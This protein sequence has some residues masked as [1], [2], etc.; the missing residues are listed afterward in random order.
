MKQ[1]LRH[2]VI[3][4]MVC[5]ISLF[6]TTPVMAIPPLPSSFYGEVR[7]NG[8][9]V[10]DGSLVRALING[11]AYAEGFTQTYAGA[12]VYVLDIPGDDVSTPILEGGR[13]GEMIHFQVGG[14]LVEQSGVWHSGVNAP[15][16]LT[17]SV[18]EVLIVTQATPSPVSTQTPIGLVQPPFTDSVSVQLSPTDSASVQPFVTA[19]AFAQSALVVTS[20]GQFLSPTATS[21]QSSQETV[22]LGQPSIALTPIFHSTPILA[23]SVNIEKN[24]SVYSTLI[25]TFAAMVIVMGGLFLFVRKKLSIITKSS[26]SKHTIKGDFQ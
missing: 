8:K 3:S 10:A 9:N 1:L 23:A 12:S 26:R 20:T 22:T 18:D 13:A 19:T 7:V 25:V 6:I 5:L 2:F 24:D 11:Q 17:A 21:S 4:L 16:D 14:I 15:L